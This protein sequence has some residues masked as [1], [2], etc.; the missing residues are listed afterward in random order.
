M[1]VYAIYAAGFKSTRGMEYL[2]RWMSASFWGCRE[3]GYFSPIT[4]IRLYAS[5]ASQFILDFVIGSS[6]L[7]FLNPRSLR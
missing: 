6:F 2:P 5:I 7:R 3:H 1:E 4:P